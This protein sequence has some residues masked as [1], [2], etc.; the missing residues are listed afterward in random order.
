MHLKSAS[1]YRVPRPL[2]PL[3]ATTRGALTRWVLALGACLT[4]E[5]APRW[6]LTRITRTKNCTDRAFR[7][8]QIYKSWRN[9]L[10]ERGSST[11][12][13]TLFIFSFF[14]SLSLEQAA[15]NVWEHTFD[16]MQMNIFVAASQI[17]NEI[18]RHSELIIH[19][20]YNPCGLF[21]YISFET[22]VRIRD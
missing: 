17:R 14:F 8:S 20:S 13:W 6:F 9:I 19:E 1:Q 21:V 22:D 4:T 7:R 12:L 16:S 11:T 18:G 10:G 2:R 3:G 5:E 15:R